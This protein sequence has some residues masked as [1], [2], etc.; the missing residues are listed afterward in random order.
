MSRLNSPQGF[1]IL[2]SPLSGGLDLDSRSSGCA[3]LGGGVG[4]PLGVVVE[5]V[6]QILIIIKFAMRMFGLEKATSSLTSAFSLD[7]HTAPAHAAGITLRTRTRT[8]TIPCGIE[9]SAAG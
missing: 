4:P 8:N 2:T 5:E 1:W 9:A 7:S 6:A 3:R